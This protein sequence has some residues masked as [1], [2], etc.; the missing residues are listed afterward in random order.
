MVWELYFNLKLKFLTTTNINQ[1]GKLTKILLRSF[2]DKNF[3]GGYFWV[4]LCNTKRL[5]KKSNI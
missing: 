3:T 2:S 4:K 5:K 1:I